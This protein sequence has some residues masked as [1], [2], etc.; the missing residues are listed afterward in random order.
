MKNANV[1]IE[2]KENFDSLE[3]M[4]QNQ[5][6]LSDVLAN[7][8]RYA[9]KNIVG[10]PESA[11]SKEQM[12]Q[13]NNGYAK[14]FMDSNPNRTYARIGETLIEFETLMPDQ[15]SKVKEKLVIGLEYSLAISPQKFS[16]MR[17]GKDADPSQHAI[18]KVIRDKF[19]DYK[20]MKYKN[21]VSKCKELL[22][23][24]KRERNATDDF[25]IRLSPW[26]DAMEKTCKIAVGKGDETA[27]AKKFTQAKIKFMI[28]YKKIV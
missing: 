26:F 25:I 16:K 24:A 28:E 4:A 3:S 12:A 11:P 14:T 20:G 5:A 17:T 8:A 23:K 1:V 27:D 7:H 19:S 2:V 21:L 9:M 10:F 15:Q 18:L 13:L 22:P 6:R